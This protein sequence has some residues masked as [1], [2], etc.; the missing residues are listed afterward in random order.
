[1]NDGDSIEL[2]FSAIDKAVNSI[3]SIVGSLFGSCS[4][5]YYSE[6]M[7]PIVCIVSK[8]S[9]HENPDYDALNPINKKK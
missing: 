2:K 1:M 4:L 3:G 6:E 7:V 8:K 5:D 9:W